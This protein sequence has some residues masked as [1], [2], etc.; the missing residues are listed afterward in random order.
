MSEQHDVAGHESKPEEVTDSPVKR[1]GAGGPIII[2]EQRVSDDCSDEPLQRMREQIRNLDDVILRS[3][4]TPGENRMENGMLDSAL[5]AREF[6][7]G[8][9]YE[10]YVA[11]GTADQQKA[12]G[13]ILEQARPT[14]AQRE[15]LAGFQREM[16]VL[17]VS[18]VWCGD[19][20]QQCPLIQ[21]IAEANADQIRLRFV[22][23]DEHADLSRHVRINAGGR[24][25]VAIFMAE[26]FEFCS[27]F[28]DRPLARYRAIAGH[29]LGPSCPLPGAPV[30]DD[31]LAATLADWLAEFERV[32]LMLRLSPRLRQKHGD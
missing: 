31:E 9:D 6:E 14:D 15:L 2:V 4:Y 27:L 17:V 10:S 30:P 20:A 28:G 3:H 11:T 8:S 22:D 13:K 21:R 5:L 32:Q 29:Q 7:A 16:N 18:G 24:V 1:V 12:W 19:C 25:P 23:R 26:D